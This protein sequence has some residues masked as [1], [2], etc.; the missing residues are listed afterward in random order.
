MDTRA[1]AE[2]AAVSQRTIRFWIES[3]RILAIRIGYKYQIEIKSL[4]DY[5]GYFKRNDGRYSQAYCI[6]Q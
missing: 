1:A 5:D 4:K 2:L 6:G 3:G